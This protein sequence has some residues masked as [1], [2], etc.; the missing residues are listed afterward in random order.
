[1]RRDPAFRH[2]VLSAYEHACAFC[3]FN[4][5]LGAS[6]LGLEAAH[7]KW[8][9]AGGPSELDNGIACCSLH[10]LALDRGAL[11]LDPELR[12]LVSARLSGTG[13]VQDLFVSLAG[14]RL[15]KPN[16]SGALPRLDYIAWHSKEVF[17]KPHRDL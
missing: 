12:I 3:G 17:R 6:D 1:L 7:L 15:R 14:K 8:H 2:E 9:Q 16:R 4:A 10:H 11:G 13:R 5:R